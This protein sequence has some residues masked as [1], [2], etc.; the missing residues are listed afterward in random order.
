MKTIEGEEEG[1]GTNLP[2]EILLP[3]RPSMPRPLNN[4]EDESNCEK[5]RDEY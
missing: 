4:E 2:T 5:N 3:T 1:E